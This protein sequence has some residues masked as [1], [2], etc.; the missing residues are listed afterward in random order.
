MCFAFGKPAIFAG[1]VLVMM[2]AMSDFGVVHYL[3][4]NSL[5]VG[6]YK[7]WFGLG[8]FNS[9]ARLATI[10]FI[11]AFFSAFNRKPIKKK[12]KEKFFH[13]IY[14]NKK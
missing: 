10:L 5:S 7:S 6:I 13:L 3:G 4:I 12:M 14:L 8:D 1:L 9:A 11:L 2:E